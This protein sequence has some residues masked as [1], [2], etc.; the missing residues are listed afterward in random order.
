MRK[1]FVGDFVRTRYG[2][3]FVRIVSTW[4]KKI[5]EMEEVE[6]IY[7]SNKC[8]SEVGKKFRDIWVELTVELRNRSIVVVQAIDVVVV[9][10]RDNENKERVD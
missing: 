6:A 4:R 9:K 5:L 1:F 7:F 2:D 8:Y 3:G 10:G